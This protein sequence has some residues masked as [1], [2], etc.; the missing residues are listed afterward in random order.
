MGRGALTYVVPLSPLFF[1]LA[2]SV[3]CC[4]PLSVTACGVIYLSV[5]TYNVFQTYKPSVCGF[6]YSF[7][8]MAVYLHAYMFSWWTFSVSGHSHS[9]ISDSWALVGGERGRDGEGG[10][11]L[12]FLYS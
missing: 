8:Y 12:L 4:F 3:V 2:A 5:R 1:R 10:C 7:R 11:S 6:I 9:K